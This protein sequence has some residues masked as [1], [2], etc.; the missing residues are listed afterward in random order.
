MEN[1]Q[2][3]NEP[4]SSQQGSSG[5]EEGTIG[6]AAD[7][8]TGYSSSDSSS[9]DSSSSEEEAS[10]PANSLPADAQAENA[11][12]TVVG[13]IEDLGAPQSEDNPD[14]EASQQGSEGTATFGGHNTDGH[15]QQDVEQMNVQERA[16][17][18][19]ALALQNDS[20]ANTDTNPEQEDQE[21]TAQEIFDLEIA[22]ALQ[23]EEDRQEATHGV[24]DQDLPPE[25]HE[26]ACGEAYD[27]REF[28][29]LV[30]LECG[31]IRCPPCFNEN[32]SVGLEA[33]KNFPP[34]CC[35]GIPINIEL[36]KAFLEPDVKQR[37][38]A[39][40]AEYTDIAPVYCATK[41]CSAYLPKATIT[42]DF[43]WAVCSAC[44]ASSQ[45]LNSASQLAGSASS[46]SGT[47][48]SPSPTSPTEVRTCTACLHVESDHDPTTP[49]TCPDR[50]E[51]MDKDLFTKRGWKS[52]PS[53]REM[54]EKS[55]GCD[56]MQCDCGHEFCYQCGRSYT[57]GMPCNCHGG[58][59]WVDEVDEEE[60]D[61]DMQRQILE[62]IAGGNGDGQEPGEVQDAAA[63]WGVPFHNRDG[64]WDDG[65]EE[66]EEEV[67]LGDQTGE[68]PEA[69]T[70]NPHDDVDG[71]ANNNNAGHGLAH[72]DFVPAGRGGF[73]RGRGNFRGRGDVLGW[74]RGR[75]RGR[76]RGWGP[77]FGP[78]GP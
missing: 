37:Y 39:V 70:T 12:S 27:W 76:G 13:E 43:R 11:S 69:D 50:I 74:G 7:T 53:C 45:S 73:G 59:A 2:P 33:R 41:S 38:E 51:R 22:I 72:A 71:N 35:P 63:G 6:V 19:F 60:N 47:E 56:H 14:H 66:E 18:E 36:Y 23:N 64:D 21:L 25:T 3:A 54:I 65:D 15:L 32:V 40:K 29:N 1:E 52:C 34:R 9:N 75:G 78:N 31:H 46:S 10:V 4:L 26:C 42:P 8:V 68:V 62:G 30:W 61:P 16:D 44:T 77:P 20:Q 17:F 49:S 67:Q 58:N 48:S 55:N 24:V 57:G 5:N 28:P